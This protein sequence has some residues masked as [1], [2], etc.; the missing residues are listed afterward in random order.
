MEAILTA[1]EVEARAAALALHCPITV[2][3]L[4]QFVQLL[5]MLHPPIQKKPALPHRHRGI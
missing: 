1:Q 3:L 4:L 2:L 5:L